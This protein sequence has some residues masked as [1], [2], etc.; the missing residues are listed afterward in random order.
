MLVLTQAQENLLRKAVIRND[1]WR[2]RAEYKHLEVDLDKWFSMSFKSQMYHLNIVYSEL[3]ESVPHDNSTANDINGD[4]ANSEELAVTYTE[5][6]N[7][8]RITTSTLEDIWTKGK[9]L[10]QTPGL[11]CP[12]PGQGNS[13]NRMVASVSNSEPHYIVEKNGKFICSGNCLRFGAYK[14]C[15]H[16]VAAAQ[17]FGMLP[18]FCNWWKSQKTG[19]NVDALAMAGLPKGAGQKGGVP[20]RGRRSRQGAMLSS[21]VTELH[22]DDTPTTSSETSIN[23]SQTSS[24]LLNSVASASNYNSIH[25]SF[26]N[27]MT[28]YDYTCNPGQYANPYPPWPN[29]SHHIFKSNHNAKFVPHGIQPFYLKMLTRQIRVC[30]GC[31]L[32]RRL[33]GQAGMGNARLKI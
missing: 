23:L 7:P 14:I 32:H 31:Q 1:R 22:A 27:F 33:Q 3:L 17:N 30:A 16:T 13:N 10:V 24:A 6:I 25:H 4:G 15:Q 19:A 9:H 28:I 20:K 8:Y 29:I 11:V 12:V 18:G 5:L 26:N 21:T 2:F